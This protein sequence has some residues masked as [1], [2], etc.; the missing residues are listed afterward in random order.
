MHARVRALAIA[1]CG[2]YSAT[3]RALRARL[4]LARFSWGPISGGGVAAFRRS[5]VSSL[6]PDAAVFDMPPCCC[7]ACGIAFD[8]NSRIDVPCGIGWRR[9][10]GRGAYLERCLEKKAHAL[11]RALPAGGKSTS[12]PWRDY[13]NDGYL[14]TNTT[15]L[16]AARR[17]DLTRHGKLLPL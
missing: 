3:R 4:T 9:G 8:H 7:M 2:D 5:L 10:F 15:V 14:S 11:C 12:K 16:S 6:R 1:P 17:A 13:G